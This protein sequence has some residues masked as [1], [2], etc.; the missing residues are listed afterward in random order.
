M[1]GTQALMLYSLSLPTLCGREDIAKVDWGAAGWRLDY[2][3]GYFLAPYSSCVI[4]G[5]LQKVYWF[6]PEST[7]GALEL[8][9]V[10]DTGLV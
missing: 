6:Q 9:R 4:P 5:L 10:Q 7:A 8:N 1:L 2:F 3:T